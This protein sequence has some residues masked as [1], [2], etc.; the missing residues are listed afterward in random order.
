MKTANKTKKT[1]NSTKK[2][3]AKATEKDTK[4]LQIAGVTLIG[5][6]AALIAASVE[7]PLQSYAKELIKNPK[8]QQ[9]VANAIGFFF[10]K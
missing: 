9:M 1:V 3:T 6:G 2:T 8:A 5:A 10:N 7:S 4:Q